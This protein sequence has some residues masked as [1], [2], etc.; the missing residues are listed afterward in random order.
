MRLSELAANI[1]F[2]LDPDE[3]TLIEIDAQ[4]GK[5]RFSYR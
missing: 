3:M 2:V 5:A 4:I 1:D